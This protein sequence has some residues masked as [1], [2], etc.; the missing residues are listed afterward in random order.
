MLGSTSEHSTRRW[1]RDMVWLTPARCRIFAATA[2]FFWVSF[3]SIIIITMHQGYDA[4]GDPFGKD[5]SSFWAASRMVLAGMPADVYDPVLHRL[6]ESP[7]HTRGHTSFFYPPTF[8][9][10]C[11]PLAMLPFFPSLAVFLGVTGAAFIGT[12]HR[13]L[14]ASWVIPAMFA[15]PLV[16]M[17]II[18]GQNAFLTASLLGGGLTI[19]DRRPALAGM[20]LGMMSVKPHLA[21]AVPFALLISRNW[22]ALLCAA[23]T[24]AGLAIASYWL[25]GWAPWAAFLTNTAGGVATLEQGYVG[26]SK[27]Q[28]TFALMRTF[29]ASV[30]VSYAVHAA[31]A[32]LS[33]GALIWARYRGVSAAAWHSLIVLATLLMTPFI[34]HYD[35]VLVLLPLAWMARSWMDRGF[36]P[37]SRLVM[38]VTF[39]VPTLFIFWRPMP[40]GMP[41]AALLGGYLIWDHI[42][43]HQAEA[44]H[45]PGKTGAAPGVISPRFARHLVAEPAYR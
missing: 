21:L 22:T 37:W 41:V 45:G 7:V 10:L 30:A 13:I 23:G 17:N 34:L 26:F 4:S 11:T 8:L 2:A 35:M 33:L 14:K 12:L 40:F 38:I 29:G 6:A 25:L 18:T 20:L 31:V 1:F 32:A 39:F 44:S 24:A 36:P 9:L 3:L 27:M 28:S 5:F 43:G 16:A 19:L 42:N 15:S